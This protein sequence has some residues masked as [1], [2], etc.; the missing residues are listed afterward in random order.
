ME[1]NKKRILIVEDEEINRKI[2]KKGLEDIYEIVEAENGKEGMEKIEEYGLSISA[3]L[4]DLIMPVADGFAVLKFMNEYAYITEIPVICITADSRYESEKQAFDYGISDFVI[5][6]FH[7]EIVK[8]RVKNMI[9]LFERTNCLRQLVEE[10]TVE[11]YEQSEQ[12][13]ELLLNLSEDR[14]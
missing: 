2:L 8:R 14:E 3:I 5:K 11:I 6:P 10:Q 12:I 7:Q 4:L 1:E 9:D 13:Q